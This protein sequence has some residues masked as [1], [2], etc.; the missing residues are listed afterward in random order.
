MV[1]PE[2]PSEERRLRL[3]RL[4]GAVGGFRTVTGG[5]SAAGRWVV[6]TDRGA[7][8]V[9]AAVDDD[10]ARWIHDE[11]RIFAARMSR[12]CRG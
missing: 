3:H 8:F 12:S 5:F 7:V 2:S 6:D 11:A 4:L 10:T 9:K 1:R